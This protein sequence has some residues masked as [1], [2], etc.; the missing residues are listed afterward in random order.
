MVPLGAFPTKLA[1]RMVNAVSRIAPARNAGPMV[2]RGN[3]GMVATSAGRLTRS[4]KMACAYVLII[5]IRSLRLRVLLSAET[6]NEA[7]IGWRLCG[8]D[9]VQGLD[10]SG[11]N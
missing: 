11:R 6:D 3:A 8:P 10:I 1:A 5:V 2:A 9:G 4:A 7:A